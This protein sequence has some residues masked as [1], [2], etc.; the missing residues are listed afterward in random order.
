MLPRRL[1]PLAVLLCALVPSP[2]IAQ[3]CAGFTDVSAAS[4]FCPNVEWLKN[5]AITLGCGSTTYCPNDPVSRLAMAAFMNRLGNVLTP[6][7][8]AVDGTPGALDLD[9]GPVVCA[10]ADLALAGYPRRA[11]FDGVVSAT[12]PAQVDFAVDVVA[13]TNAGATWAA[14]ATLGALG[15]FAA[16]RWG[17]VATLAQADLDVPQSIRFG[18]RASRG[19]LPGTTDLSDSRCQLRV[20]VYSR[21][22]TATPY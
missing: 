21:T 1:A 6:L 7:A 2:A 10:T 5:R 9:A 20:N 18:L 19:G 15:G 4:S 13:S 14:V 17:M 16:N 3:S 12:A 11:Q 8:L 22:G